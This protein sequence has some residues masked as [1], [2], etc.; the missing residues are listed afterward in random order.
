M[1]GRLGLIRSV[2]EF[3]L[4]NLDDSL[5]LGSLLVALLLLLLQEV[6]FFPGLSERILHH[7]GLLLIRL[8]LLRDGNLLL[9]GDS[10]LCTL[11]ALVQALHEI[12]S[13]D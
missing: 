2:L 3:G 13:L 8:Q 10:L 4:E 6:V 11:Q 7:L 5:V 1:G 12:R 9:V